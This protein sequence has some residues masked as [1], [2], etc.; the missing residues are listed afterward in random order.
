MPAPLRRTFQSL[1]EPV[2]I[3]NCYLGLSLTCFEVA[4]LTCHPRGTHPRHCVDRSCPAGL[5]DRGETGGLWSQAVWIQV[6]NVV[7]GCLSFCPW[8]LANLFVPTCLCPGAA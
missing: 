4:Q 1:I 6:T 3:A 5:R 8:G 7:T 2:H